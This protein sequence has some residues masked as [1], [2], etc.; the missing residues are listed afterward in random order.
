MKARRVIRRLLQTISMREDRGGGKRWT[1]D[2]FG[3][4]LNRTWL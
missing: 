2:M 3:R 4:W 1:G